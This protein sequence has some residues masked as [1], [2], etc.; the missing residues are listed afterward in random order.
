[1]FTA[2][3]EKNLVFNGLTEN[4]ANTDKFE[5]KARIVYPMNGG[6]ALVTFEE[7]DGE[8]VFSGSFSSVTPPEWFDPPPYVGDLLSLN[9]IC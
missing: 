6:T 9:H 8:F 7:E 2:V 5:M 3:P 1:M 4:A